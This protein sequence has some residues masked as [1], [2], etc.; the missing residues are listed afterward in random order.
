MVGIDDDYVN[1]TSMIY[2]IFNPCAE[3]AREELGGVFVT[4]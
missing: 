2:V 4:A 3:I 1:M